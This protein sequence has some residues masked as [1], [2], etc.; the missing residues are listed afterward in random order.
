MNVNVEFVLSSAPHTLPHSMAAGDDVTRPVP[1]PV[2]VSDT[3]GC[4]EAVGTI[5]YKPPVL[6]AL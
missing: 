4:V 3:S 1:L 6:S 2:L 5:L